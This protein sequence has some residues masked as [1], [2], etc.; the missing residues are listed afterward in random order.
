[1]NSRDPIL[2]TLFSFCLGLLFTANT[3]ADTTQELTVKAKQ[4]DPKAQYQ[5]AVQLEKHQ[6]DGSAVDALYWYQQSADLGYEPAQFKL[7]QS[8]E[9]GLGTSVD[10]KQAA[11]WYLHAALQGNQQALLQLGALFEKE[12]Q[13]FSHLDLAQLWFGL[14]AKQNEKADAEYNRILELKFNQLRAKQVSAISQLDSALAE[15]SDPSFT[16]ELHQE[17]SSLLFPIYKDWWVLVI[18]LTIIALVTIARAVRKRR[19]TQQI[20]QHLMLEKE[21]KNQ[22]FNNKQLKR[23]LEKV[24]NEYKKIQS[25]NKNHKL[26]LAC[27]MFGYLPSNI[28]DEKSIKI[29]FRQL[30]K[31]YHPDAQGSEEEMKRLNGA[32]KVLLQ[33]VTSR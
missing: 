30:S 6:T 29:R 15:P 8:F 27:A 33:N 21:L 32:L 4:Q 20:D 7:A 23:Q 14:T 25:Q 16:T 13:Q 31:L 2:R 10:V 9:Q 28:P 3:L 11:N 1:M 12:G 18:L 26:A 19:L 17:E 5:L 24:F 22:Q